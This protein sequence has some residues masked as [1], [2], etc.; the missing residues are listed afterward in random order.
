MNKRKLNYFNVAAM[1]VG[2]IMGAGFASGREGWQFFGVFGMKGYIGLGISG[3]LFIA[4]GVMISY[5]AIEL[6]TKDMGKIIVFSENEK[7]AEWVGR[8]LAAIL[9]TI[10]I[11]MSAAG[12]SFLHQQFGCHQAV[13]GMIIV[14]LV[15]ITVLGNF[16][17]LSKVFRWIIP[18][19]FVLDIG[20][21]ISV[22]FSDIEQSGAVSGFP[23]SSLAPRWGLAA[24][25]FTAYNMLGTIPIVAE[26][27]LNA[28]NRIHGILGGCLGGIM[29]TML[30]AF[31]VMTLRKDM[32]FTQSM[33]L[34][35]LAY[36]EKLGI[37]PNVIFGVILF[38]AI[39]S[40]ATSLYYGFSTKIKEGP[41]KK[42]ILIFGAVAGFVLGL[43]GFK[44]VVSFLYPLEGYAGLVIMTSITI[45]FIK[46]VVK[47]RRA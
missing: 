14:V 33:D 13:G 15:L 1:Y 31:L 34:P 39:Y 43:S 37:V 25:L 4:M 23:V 3:L 18:A 28:K 19:L 22:I 41:K 29:L 47:K 5:I 12:G 7:A 46:L 20:L 45:H 32:E 38:A 42:Y 17:R 16:E 26:A 35:M 40:A 10:I 6:N 8:F 30:T 24:V 2:A 9:Y 27:S 21:C 44:S 11:S 36:S